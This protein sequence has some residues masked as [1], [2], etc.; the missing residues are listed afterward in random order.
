VIQDPVVVGIASAFLP[1]AWGWAIGAAGVAAFFA[2]R[3]AERAARVRRAC[4]AGCRRRP[5]RWW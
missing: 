1:S 3:M 4:G 2:V 5:G